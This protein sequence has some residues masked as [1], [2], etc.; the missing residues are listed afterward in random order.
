MTM[1]AFILG[2]LVGTAAGVVAVSLCAVGADADERAR[3]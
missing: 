1:L 2:C 3:R